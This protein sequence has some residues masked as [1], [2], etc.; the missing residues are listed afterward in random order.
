MSCRVTCA[1]NSGHS[2]FWS[3]QQSYKNTLIKN[4]KIIHCRRYMT[5]QNSTTNSALLKLSNETVKSQTLFN[6]NCK[7]KVDLRSQCLVCYHG[8]LLYSTQPTQPLPDDSDKDKVDKKEKLT[9]YQR[10]KKMYKE[11]WY[12]LIPV[13]LATSSVWFGGFYYLAAW[14]VLVLFF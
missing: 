3:V 1:L 7:I 6:L 14:L 4:K 5:T 13:H 11:Y 2:M 9:L 10:L 12:V 8:N